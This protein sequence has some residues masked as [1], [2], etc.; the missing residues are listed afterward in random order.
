MAGDRVA[1]AGTVVDGR[2]LAI[3]RYRGALVWLMVAGNYLAGVAAV[4]PF[5]KHAPDLGLTVADLVAPCF[6]F[7][8]G[9]TAGP[10]FERRRRTDGLGHAV[11]HAAMRNLALIG[12]GALISAGGTAVGQPSSWGV[13]QALGEAGLI[14]LLVIGLPTWAR[15]VIGVA[16]LVAYQLALDRWTL[17]A[18][19]G[20]D[21]GGIVGGVAWGALLI[22]ST[23]VADLWRRGRGALAA[24]T[25]VLA[26][27]ATLSVF[28]VPVSKH[29]VSLSY[30]L[31]TLAIAA[32]AFLLTDLGARFV[33]R[34]PG[35]LAWWGE[36]PLALY[37][38]Q[39][40]LLGVVVLPPAP[41]WYADAPL[42]LAGIQLAAILALLSIAARWLHRRRVRMHL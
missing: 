35:Y 40:L 30:V 42:W 39:L 29:R 1:R 14:A 17:D 33:P 10:S 26:A 37:L 5:L 41:G 9:L 12:I 20:A 2:D 8:I 11:R 6:V 27:V 22:C 25:A 3:D 32:F 13:L 28:L 18:V 31:V 7:A 36:N 19:L 38:L 15:L 4:P 24:T 16:M 23:G 21:H 34:R